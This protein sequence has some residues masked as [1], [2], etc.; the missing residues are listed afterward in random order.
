MN[1]DQKVTMPIT[2]EPDTTEFLRRKLA[3]TGM[4]E[5]QSLYINELIRKD[6]DRRGI[7][8]KTNRRAE[9]TETELIELN[10]EMQIPAGE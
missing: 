5:D 6:R 2:L 4:P 1:A 3:N 10:H 9:V 8:A 7:E